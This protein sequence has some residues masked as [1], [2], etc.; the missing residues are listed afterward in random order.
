MTAKAGL[1]N[2]R[3]SNIA[4]HGSRTPTRVSNQKQYDSIKQCYE[5]T[6]KTGIAYLRLSDEDFKSGKSGKTTTDSGSIQNQR[7]AIQQYC[8][9]MNILIIQEFVDDGYS[10][11][12]FDRPGFNKMLDYLKTHRVDVVLTKDLSRLGRDMRE[13]SYYAETFFPEAD[14]HY[15]AIND[16]FDSE[17]D[18]PLA[19]FQFAMNDVFLRET[20]K[21]IRDVLNAKKKAGEYAACAPFGYAKD[22]RD[23][24]KLIPDELTAPIV[25]R[26]FSL[27]SKG[28]S[29]RA[30]CDMLNREHVIPPLKY[31]AE[32]TG[33][34]TDKGIAKVADEWNY[35]TVKRILRNEVYLGHTLLGRTRKVSL[36]AKRVMTV[37]KSD[38]LIT[39]N[40]HEP[41]V[42]EEVF[43]AVQR[44]L[45][46]STKEWQ[47]YGSIR[48]SIFGG[49][50]FCAHCGAALC[51][52]G[53]VYKGEREKY[54]YLQCNN[55][56]KRSAK[57]CEHPAR[58][59]YSDFVEIIREELNSFINLSDEDIEEVIRSVQ[60]E[61]QSGQSQRQARDSIRS[62]EKRQKQIDAMITKLYMDNVAGRLNDDRLSRMVD[63]LQH[64]FD[65]N[66]EKMKELEEAIVNSGH[67]V[68]HYQQFFDL[69]K[70][71]T[72]I[73]TLTREIV[74]T[75]IDRIE[76]SERILPEGVT[77]AGPKTPYKQEIHIYYR[78]IGDISETPVREVCRPGA[79]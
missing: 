70:R 79:E 53:S 27:A 8:A 46:A 75:F 12:N 78:F 41:L 30:I 76:V 74:Q 67:V 21:K 28:H 34:F 58:I 31:R 39:T 10:G 37:D 68:D 6:A 77:I 5:M 47:Q 69:V 36:K 44:N 29:T 56:P 2:M 48:R 11:G 19:P 60:A 61:T 9:R 3:I 38:W 32:Y 23:E 1:P 20:S 16:N 33:T 7:T 57:H 25:Q 66:I 54:W 18:N 63:S 51:S 65:A 64:E 55:L 62:I 50:V 15:I 72:H 52:A 45:K 13:S 14:I 59:K 43:N 26:I 35:V 42:S 71:S 17:G 49:I 73:E 24:N 4:Y 22:P 40:T